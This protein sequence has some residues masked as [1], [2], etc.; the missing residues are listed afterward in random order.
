MSISE[1]SF[2]APNITQTADNECWNEL[3]QNSSY[4]D[5]CRNGINRQVSP[6]YECV[7]EQG[8]SSKKMQFHSPRFRNARTPCAYYIFSRSSTSW[9]TL[10]ARIWHSGVS[11]LIISC[12]TVYSEWRHKRLTFTKPGTLH[13]WKISYLWKFSC[14]VS[15]RSEFLKSFFSMLKNLK[16]TF[17]ALHN[18]F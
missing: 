12:I 8:R 7:I 13:F 3:I 9:I 5:M 11:I 4:A 6:H 17:T 15:H 18:Q 1:N 2:E 14:L 16:F 10:S